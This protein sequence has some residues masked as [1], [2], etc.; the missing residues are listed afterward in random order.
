MML[1]YFNFSQ[2]VILFFL[3]FEFVLFSISV[4]FCYYLCVSCYLTFIQLLLVLDVFNLIFFFSQKKENQNFYFIHFLGFF[5]F[6]Q[7]LLRVVANC[8]YKQCSNLFNLFWLNFLFI[9]SIILFAI[10]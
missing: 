5:L 8:N 2:I 1:L 3:V 6:K 4:C 9:Y 7:P 10:V